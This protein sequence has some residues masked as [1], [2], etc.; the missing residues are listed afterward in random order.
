M[1]DTNEGLSASGRHA[2]QPFSQPQ[3]PPQAP[4][5]RGPVARRSSWLDQ[6]PRTLDVAARAVCLLAG[7]GLLV[8]GLVGLF[9]D[10]DEGVLA[11]VLGIGVL[12]LITPSIIDRIRSTRL[13]QFEVQLV[14][15]VAASARR[16]ANSLQRLGLGRELDAYA[17]IYTELRGPE[18]KNV[19]AMVLD[20]IIERVAGAAVVEKFDQ[21]EVKAMF[22]E[23]TPIVRVLALGL[24]EGDPSL[25]DGEILLE[26]VSRPLTGNE[27]YHALRLVRD[28]WNRLSPA[29]HAALRSAIDASPH[30][31][32]GSARGDVARQIRALHG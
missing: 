5:P 6:A 13:G 17:T 31:K 27:Q 22:R 25:I 2:P 3:M 30:L 12:L 11:L 8:T 21:D 7:V 16:A 28:E 19:R 20:R 14:R 4:G 29:E 24:M 26:A 32:D 9:S 15:Q 23:G 18:L 1:S 10:V